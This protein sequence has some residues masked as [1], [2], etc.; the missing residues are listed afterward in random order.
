L[1]VNFF[2]LHLSM[3]QR[4]LCVFFKVA[5]KRPR[6]GIVEELKGQISEVG[7]VTKH[8]HRNQGGPSDSS[9]LP[10]QRLHNYIL[11]AHTLD[12]PHVGCV[13]GLSSTNEPMPYLIL[14]YFSNGDIINYLKQN[15]SKTDKEKKEL[16]RACIACR[17]YIL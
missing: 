16:V 9:L 3:N 17:R 5:L 10:I 12:H 1:F 8:T 11:V 6:K 7:S 13:L 15:Q 4:L 2:L 14:P